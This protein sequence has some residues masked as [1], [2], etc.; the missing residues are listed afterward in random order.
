MG[1]KHGNQ[2]RK[3]GKTP[4]IIHPMRVFILLRWAGYSEFMDENMMVAALLHDILE[5][6]DTTSGEIEEKFGPE[7]FSIVM[8]LTRPKGMKKEQWLKSFETCSREAKIIKL[9]DRIDNLIDLK[10][11][12]LSKNWKYSY[13]KQGEIILKTCGDADKKLALELKRWIQDILNENNDMS[14]I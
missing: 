5:D 12:H 8:E 3:D 14:P 10:G 6:T 13:A 7:I 11:N 4:Y 1:K 9:A 2:L